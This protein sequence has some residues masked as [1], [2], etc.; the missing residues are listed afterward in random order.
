M[1]YSLGM[2]VTS[3]PAIDRRRVV[4]DPNFGLKRVADTS[5]GERFVIL[6]DGAGRYAEESKPLTESDA[7]RV[8]HKMGHPATVIEL[9]VGRAKAT[10]S[11]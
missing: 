2:P 7:R 4:R 11:T 1:R 5:R 10:P 9:M 8:L 3:R 6:I